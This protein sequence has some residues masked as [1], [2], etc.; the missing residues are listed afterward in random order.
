MTA[1]NGASFSV[2]GGR[3]VGSLTHLLRCLL[4][5]YMAC[6]ADTTES[7]VSCKC[8]H[9]VHSRPWGSADTSS[10][11]VPKTDWHHSAHRAQICRSPFGGEALA[12][13]APAHA[14]CPRCASN[15]TQ[16]EETCVSSFFCIE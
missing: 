9:S 5:A 1:S 11:V 4:G 13:H 16:G 2:R 12:Q 6:S 14:L 10:G 8:V 3:A 15:G 7:A